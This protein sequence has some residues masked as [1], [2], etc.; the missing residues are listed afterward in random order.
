MTDKPNLTLV[1]DN[2]EKAEELPPLALDAMVAYLKQS[3][4]LAELPTEEVD[5]FAIVFHTDDGWSIATHID[6]PSEVVSI[7][8]SAA[9]SVRLRQTM[10]EICK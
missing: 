7:L 9:F 10:E 5:T 4:E 2:K 1:T 8:D 6:T 3:K